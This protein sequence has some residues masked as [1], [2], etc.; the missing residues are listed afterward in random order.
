MRSES[1]KYLT[2]A[3]S[4]AVLCA[5]TLLAPAE[6]GK[7]AKSPAG[8]SAKRPM[9]ALLKEANALSVQKNYPAAVEKYKK[10]CQAEPSNPDCFHFYG[11]TLAQ[12]GLETDAIEQYRKALKL[13]PG[14]AELFNDLG[15]ALYVN[16]DDIIS[17]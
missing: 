13:K 16:E 9:S 10:A 17:A 8:A 15:C 4:L 2:L 7:S 5:G 14:D 6:A 1:L 3:A 11:R 12:M